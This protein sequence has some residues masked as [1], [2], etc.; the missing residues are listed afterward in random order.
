MDAE[1][2]FWRPILQSLRL[3][4]VGEEDFFKKLWSDGRLRYSGKTL[5]SGNVEEMSARLLSTALRR[6]KSLFVVLPEMLPRNAP[7]LF[8]SALLLEAVSKLEAKDT[9][10]IRVTLMSS[11][12]AMRAHLD[13]VTVHGTSLS[14][15]FRQVHLREDAKRTIGATGAGVGLSDFLPQV[16]C[17]LSPALPRSVL[18]RYR[19]NWIAIDCDG[20]NDLEWLPEVLALAR[21]REI[22]VI[23]WSFGYFGG[24]AAAVRR[25]QY[26][27]FMWPPAVGRSSRP[28]RIVNRAL[29]PE[30]LVDRCV[31]PTFRPVVVD[32]DRPRDLSRQF[33]EAKALLSQ[34]AGRLR[35][36]F[37]DDCIRSGWHYLRALE[38]VHVPLAFF[39]AE[40]RQ[41][42]GM[43]TLAS[44]AATFK[45]FVERA[46][47]VT[48]ETR[49]DLDRVYGCLS[50]C[51]TL[52][53]DADP[54]LWSALLAMA[55]AEASSNEPRLIAFAAR[56]RRR[57][58]ELALLG[59]EGISIGD[60][61]S[62][63]V[64]LS[65]LADVSL[66]TSTQ[67]D[68]RNSQL[69]ESRAIR[70]EDLACVVG[71]PAQQQHAKLQYLFR[72]HQVHVLGLPHQEREIK[73]RLEALSAAV[74]VKAA[75][76][77][78]ALLTVGLAATPW[79]SPPEF[80]FVKVG[81]TQFVGLE[82]V[83]SD[84]GR[85]AREPVWD[86]PDA[87]KEAEWL[88]KEDTDGDDALADGVASDEDELGGSEVYEDQIVDSAI[89]VDLPDGRFV[90]LASDL[91]IN[92]IRGSGAY[93]TMQERCADTI[94][95]GD[96]LIFIHG[97]RRQSV[98]DLL[99]GRVHTHPAIQ[100]H[101]ALLNAWHD[102][103]EKGYRRWTVSTKLGY[104]SLLLELQALGC[105]RSA[106]LT[107]RFWVTAQI[108]CPS[109]PEDVRRMG[110]VLAI[111]FVTEHYKRISKA[112]DRLR[113][114]HR[115]LAN[116]LSN[117]LRTQG[118][119]SS[120]VSDDEVFDDEL[121]LRL[122]DFRESLEIVVV[123]SVER[124]EGMFLRSSLNR[125]SV[126]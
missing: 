49:Q 70:T 5:A 39:E 85:Q 58:F 6:R 78:G 56:S 126:Q 93:E 116:R 46:Q 26:P 48:P 114:L 8:A 119:G 111:P 22:P 125:F 107:V 123:H 121:G 101:L 65:S 108:L 40:C 29:S 53:S 15:V 60:L 81:Q 77:H 16:V 20:T 80:R 79:T 43:N 11:S 118:P 13:E 103:I 21:E 47:T 12:V 25:A 110:Q 4:P 61:E 54:P 90:L 113:G 24:C 19:P 34:M 105:E 117:W 76:D 64:R 30:D 51:H 122:S 55:V 69:T 97:Q 84:S 14:Q 94:R 87:V 120:R 98:Y 31:R 82:A 7:T 63:G 3:I 38:N 115:G 62:V 92:V 50:K 99:I 10:S 37:S 36:Q 23:G 9:R 33:S 89:R 45:K 102:E 100:L 96:R 109:D 59:I 52:L 41:Y 91:K 27:L 112:A 42:W 17:A 72:K 44:S 86:A 104:D 28:K 35:S 74:C 57:L 106:P 83:F 68:N 2:E 124:L 75:E 67:G 18:D 88:L 32:G 71:W 1:V 95:R 66:N 73:S